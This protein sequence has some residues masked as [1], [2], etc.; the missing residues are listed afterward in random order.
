[1]H[2]MN[3]CELLKTMIIVSNNGG[4]TRLVKPSTRHQANVRLISLN[5]F[6]VAMHVRVFVCVHPRGHKKQWRDVDFIWLAH[7]LSHISHLTESHTS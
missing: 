5:F 1:M 2:A 3:F 4:S 6:H 7:P